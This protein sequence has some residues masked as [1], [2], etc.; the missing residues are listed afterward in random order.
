MPL[1]PADIPEFYENAYAPIADG[2]RYR[3]WREL[4]AV[5]KADHVVA[6]AHRIG[7]AAPGVVAEIGCGDGAVLGELGRRGFGTTRVGF[8]ISAAA[9]RIATE[10]PEIAEVAVF[11]G[12]RLPAD[13]GAYDLAFATHVL[14]HVHAP[15]PLLREM[16]RVARAVVVEVPLERNVSARRPAARAMSEA[17]GHVQ[18]FDRAAIRRLV[19]DAG[20]PVRGEIVD[21]LGADVHLFGRGSPAAR[22]KGRA[23]W[24]VR[25]ALAVSP[26]LGTRLVT[27]HYAVVATP[28][29]AA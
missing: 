15:A 22:A 8:E 6:L 10:R 7:C 26:A 17:A 28:P 16:M 24:A 3:R 4:G 11:D 13:D 14:E 21:P 5:A 2:E 27:M 25:R 23:K 29:A 9:V 18:R 20:W 12:A 1:R 19:T